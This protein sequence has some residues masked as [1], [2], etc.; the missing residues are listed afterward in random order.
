MR[1]TGLV[2]IVR[3]RHVDEEIERRII[4]TIQILDVSTATSKYKNLKT[5]SPG[6]ATPCKSEI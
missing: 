2:S 5:L 6:M 3:I 1:I 4:T